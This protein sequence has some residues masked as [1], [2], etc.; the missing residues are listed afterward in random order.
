MSI[1]VGTTILFGMHEPFEKDSAKLDDLDVSNKKYH[2]VR[3]KSLIAVTK[4]VMT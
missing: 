3:F 2:I 4:Q 1:W